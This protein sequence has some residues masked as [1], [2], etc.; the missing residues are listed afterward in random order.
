MRPDEVV[1]RAGVSAIAQI[2]QRLGEHPDARYVET[3]A[4]IEVQPADESGFP[5][6]LHVGREGFTVHFAGWHEDF[7]SEEA[8]LD[9][10]AFGLSDACRL[11]VVYRGRTP[12]KWI[13]ESQVDGVWVRDSETGLIL[14]PF[15]RPRR[16]VHLQNRLL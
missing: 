8:A 11:R 15:W 4:S 12:T 6:G 3:P 1:W 16:V 13:V 9:C 10:F 5:V 2:K 7:D 14:V